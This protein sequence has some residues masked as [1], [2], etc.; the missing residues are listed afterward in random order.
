MACRVTL[1]RAGNVRT[2]RPFDQRGRF[3]GV[4]GHLEEPLPGVLLD[5][6]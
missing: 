3:A 1:A 2:R 5:P 4:G 6:A